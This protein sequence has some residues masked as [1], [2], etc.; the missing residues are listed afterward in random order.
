MVAYLQ[1]VQGA[2]RETHDALVANR[3]FR[4]ALAAQSVRRDALAD[5]LELADLRY[6][7]GYSGYL[8]VLDSQRQLLQAETLRI[9]AARDARIALVDLSRA[10]GGGW[11]PDSVAEASAR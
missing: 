3:T 2:F 11:S 7:A 10:L 6:R 5:A 4:E 1:T 9:T 8:E